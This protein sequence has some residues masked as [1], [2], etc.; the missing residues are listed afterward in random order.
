M[1]A[2]FFRIDSKYGFILGRV[3]F[4]III[5]VGDNAV[6]QMFDVNSKEEITND[7][8]FP[9]SYLGIDKGEYLGP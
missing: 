3:I 7:L 5:I 6:L 8:L 1:V 2:I 4:N 9:I